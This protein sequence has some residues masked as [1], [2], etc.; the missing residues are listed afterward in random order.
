MLVCLVAIRSRSGDLSCFGVLVK[1]GVPV[2]HR[3]WAMIGDKR[4]KRD[5]RNKRQSL[6]VQSRGKAMRKYLQFT[7]NRKPHGPKNGIFKWQETL[8][9]WRA[10]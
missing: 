4:D 6:E 5:N 10:L 8:D 2:H 9:H 7:L 1:G 3:V